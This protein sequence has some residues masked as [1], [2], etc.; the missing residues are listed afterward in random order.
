M[1]ED[2]KPYLVVVTRNEPAEAYLFKSTT[3]EEASAALTRVAETYKRRGQL[4]SLSTGLAVKD[5][6]L[7]NVDGL[8]KLKGLADIWLSGE[9]SQVLDHYIHLT[10]EMTAEAAIPELKRA[11]DLLQR[12]LNRSEMEIDQEMIENGDKLPTS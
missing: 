3:I 8:V 1:S 10:E 6:A 4:F 2:R 11:I 9:R 7:V 12:E 5:N